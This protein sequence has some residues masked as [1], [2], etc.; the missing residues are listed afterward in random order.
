MTQIPLLIKEK[1]DYYLQEY[2]RK[3]WMKKNKQVIQKYQKKIKI[4][5]SYGLNYQPI[6]SEI[7]W[8]DFTK[9]KRIRIL[10]GYSISPQYRV[11]SSFT[12]KDPPHNTLQVAKLPPKYYYSSGLNYTKGYK[13]GWLSNMNQQ[14][15]H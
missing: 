13:Q 6:S 8:G 1:V 4:Y 2:Y 11:V 10:Q 15:T 12:T 5:I 9:G 14:D 3:E 7:T